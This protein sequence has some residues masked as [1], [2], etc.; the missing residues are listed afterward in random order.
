[1]NW[2]GP[3]TI[4]LEEEIMA[5]IPF[6]PDGGFRPSGLYTQCVAIDEPLEIL[7]NEA[8]YFAHSANGYFSPEL[9]DGYLPKGLIPPSHPKYLGKVMLGY[10]DSKT[11]KLYLVQIRIQPACS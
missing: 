8:G 10:F 5:R 9:P 11:S 6:P 7:V 1:M 4:A 2:A 3:K